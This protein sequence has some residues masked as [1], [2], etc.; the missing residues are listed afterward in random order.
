MEMSLSFKCECGNEEISL[1][2]TLITDEDNGKVYE[3]YFSIGDSINE[4]KQFSS[5]QTHPDTIYVECRKCREEYE[6]SI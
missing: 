4:S 6:V 1:I 2:R 5:E 3:D